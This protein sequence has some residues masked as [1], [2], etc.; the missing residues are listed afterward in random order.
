M[1]FVTCTL[2]A[3]AEREESY[4]TLQ[5]HRHALKSDKYNLVEHE[6]EHNRLQQIGSQTDSLDVYA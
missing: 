4:Y 1:I 5:V 6:R 2:Q 3:H